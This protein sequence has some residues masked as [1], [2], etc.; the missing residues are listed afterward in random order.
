MISSNI[1]SIKDWYNTTF[2]IDQ[3]AFVWVV[4]PFGVNKGPLTY[5]QVISKAF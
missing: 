5:Q 1:I 4:M 3:K 2:V